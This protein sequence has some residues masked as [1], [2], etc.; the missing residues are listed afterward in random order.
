MCNTISGSKTYLTETKGTPLVVKKSEP[1]K[2]T[3]NPELQTKDKQAIKT[4]NSNTDTKPVAFVDALKEK[5]TINTVKITQAVISKVETGTAIR[6]AKASATVASEKIMAKTSETLVK[7]LTK[8]AVSNVVQTAIAVGAEEVATRAVKKGAEKALQKGAEITSKKLSMAVPVVGA[9]VGLA[10]TA[11]DA[12]YAIEVSRDKK[13]S[14]VSKV[15]AWSTV[16]LDLVATASSA[17]IVG[18]G[19]GWAA[20]GLSVVTGTLAETL[21]YRK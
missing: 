9:V 4:K 8:S 20:T 3:S 13:A 5:A 16:A 15:L 7:T 18:E 19:I 12:N 21:R 11:Y 2:V 1:E 10:V 6:V 14:T 17:T